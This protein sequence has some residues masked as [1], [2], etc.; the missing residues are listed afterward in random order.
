MSLRYSRT[1][2]RV[3]RIPSYKSRALELLDQGFLRPLQDNAVL[4]WLKPRVKV[5][6]SG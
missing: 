4:G 2:H 3:S 1:K 5:A 6:R